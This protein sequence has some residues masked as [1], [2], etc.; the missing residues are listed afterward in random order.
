MAHGVE[1]VAKDVEYGAN[2]AVRATAHGVKNVA[3]DI[4][5]GVKK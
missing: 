4:A 5:H 1:N 2:K 3:E